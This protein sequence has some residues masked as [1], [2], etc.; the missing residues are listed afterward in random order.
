MSNC[1][2]NY[3]LPLCHSV[4]VVCTGLIDI[5]A[6]KRSTFETCTSPKTNPAPTP[7][8]YIRPF[9]NLQ[10]RV[11][12]LQGMFEGMSQADGDLR[13]AGVALSPALENRID[14]LNRRW[15][16]LQL[17]LLQRQ[18]L[19]QEA[20]T[21]L[22]SPLLQRLQGLFAQGVPAVALTQI[23]ACSTHKNRQSLTK[24]LTHTPP[25]PLPHHHHHHHHLTS[26]TPLKRLVTIYF[27]NCKYVCTYVCLCLCSCTQYFLTAL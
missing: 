19:L 9:Q 11:A 20:Y 13:R 21:D 18:H 10:E 14:Q 6:Y 7:P 12:S 15:K 26:L 5:S 22:D 2:F 17:Q 25:P 27:F 8:P 4:P 16:Q 3:Q 24:L 23:S 1:C